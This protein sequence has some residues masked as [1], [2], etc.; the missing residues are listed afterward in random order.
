[1]DFIH[2]HL[3]LN[4]FPIVGTMVGVG[5]LLASFFV[6][7]EGLRRSSLVV[8]A[9]MA[10]MTIPTFVTGMG[11]QVRMLAGT[12]GVSN[13]LIQRHI[14]SAEASIWFILLTGGLSV[15]GLWQAG[16]RLHPPR[17]NTIAVLV[18]SLMTMTLMARTG[19]TGGAISHPEVRVDRQAGGLER[20]FAA[21]EPSPPAFTALMIESKWWWAFMMGLHFVGLVLVIG[22][23]GLMYLR[24]LGFA[25]LLP[26]GPLNKLVPWGLA[27]FGIN[28]VT[29]MLAF[30]G[31]S[32]YYTFD[33]AFVLKIVAILGAAAS[34]ALFYVSGAFRD[35]A[36]VPPGASAPLKAKLI[37]GASLVLWVTVI[38]LG[39]YIQPLENTIPR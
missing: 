20:L 16:R 22:T 29:G 12:P 23:I 24:V 11:A 4:H 39:R 17:W 34:T 38:V 8:F 31:M 36:A 18:F 25:R 28:V 30:I 10:L 15:I 37:A 7:S 9:T 26:I 21:I 27:G 6:H 3:L 32:A 19:N 1:M 35:C 14:G 33:L 13:E 5:L 2:L